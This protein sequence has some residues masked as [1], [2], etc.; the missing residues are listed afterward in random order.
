MI[1]IN[2]FNIKTPKYYKNIRKILEKN[3]KTD[4]FKPVVLHQLNITNSRSINFSSMFTK[5]QPLI[6]RG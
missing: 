1:L 6:I 3:D 2:F 5:S 4:D